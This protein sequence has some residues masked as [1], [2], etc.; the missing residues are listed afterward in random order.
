MGGDVELALVHGD[1]QQHAVIVGTVAVAVV[2]VEI[3]R[4]GHHRLSLQG[5]HGDNRN[6]AELIC[7]DFLQLF[8]QEPVLHFIKQSAVVHHKRQR[9][10]RT[11]GER[12][13][14]KQEHAHKKG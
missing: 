9:A 6:L 14:R 11:D 7:T 12:H 4:I 2:V 8:K 3:V 10:V 5:I 13:A 1:E